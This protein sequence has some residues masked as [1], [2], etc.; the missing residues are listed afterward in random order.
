MSRKIKKSATTKTTVKNAKYYQDEMLRLFEQK[1]G[2]YS[3]KEIFND[4]LEWNFMTMEAMKGFSIEEFRN[5]IHRLLKK[6]SKEDFED[7][8]KISD[9]LEEGLT[10]IQEDILGVVFMKMEPNKKLGQFFTPTCACELMTKLNHSEYDNLKKAVEEK[11]VFEVGDPTCGCGA[12]FINYYVN[13]KKEGI[14]T[15]KICF[16]GIDLDRRCVMMAIFQMELLEMAGEVQWGDTL[17]RKMYG[18]YI[19]SKEYIKRYGRTKLL[20]NMLMY[21]KMVDEI[22]KEMAA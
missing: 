5:T 11:D 2:K 17:T 1:A 6:Y 4:W 16:T 8:Q 13:A 9:L 22:M 19:T 14:D 3:V 21:H 20:M 7:F 15:D 10:T 12:M 18:K